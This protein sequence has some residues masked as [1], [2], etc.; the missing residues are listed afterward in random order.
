MRANSG[1]WLD[2]NPQ[3]QKFP[4]GRFP[5]KKNRM[6]VVYV[7]LAVLLFRP[8]LLVVLVAESPL[9]DISRLTRFPR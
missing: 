6:Q 3:G 9:G 8:K 5:R 2:P 1:K 7:L 4:P